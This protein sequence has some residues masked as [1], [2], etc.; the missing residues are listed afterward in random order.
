MG[1][2]ALGDAVQ[3]ADPLVATLTTAAAASVVAAND[4][5]AEINAAPAALLAERAP[6]A[7]LALPKQSALLLVRLDP[8]NPGPSPAL[9]QP[10]P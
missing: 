4:R 1:L 2:R 9:A 8:S 5:S 10:Q 3:E 7:A 6:W